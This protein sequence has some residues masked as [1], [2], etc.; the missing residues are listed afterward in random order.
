MPLTAASRPSLEARIGVMSLKTIP[1]LGKS[2][3]SRTSAARSTAM[4]RSAVSADDLAQ[5]A[6]EQQVLEVRGDRG[7]VLERLDGLLAPLRIARAQRRREDLLQQ[8]RLALRGGL[9]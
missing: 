2:G 9:E 7:E 6:D 1:G 8:R 3:M 4:E 5:I